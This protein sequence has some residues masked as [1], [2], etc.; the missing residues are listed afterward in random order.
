[1]NSYYVLRGLYLCQGA[2]LCPFNLV[3]FSVMAGKELSTLLYIK[4][5]LGEGVRISKIVWFHCRSSTQKASG[6]TEGH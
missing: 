5:M 3:P 1:M 4:A 2:L 6:V